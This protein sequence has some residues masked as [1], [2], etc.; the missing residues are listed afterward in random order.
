MTK[1]KLTPKQQKFVEG[2]AKGKPLYKAALEAYDTD[3]PRVASVI[4]AENIAKPSVRDALI[5][6]LEKHNINLDTAIAPIGEALQAVKQ[7]ITTGSWEPD[8]ST[9]LKASDRALKLMGVNST[10][11]GNVTYN[12]TQIVNEQKD[13]YKI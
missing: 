1:P 3:S 10:E 5:P 13:K 2:V 8:H 9:R 12:F 7:D 6:I 11:Q 4:A